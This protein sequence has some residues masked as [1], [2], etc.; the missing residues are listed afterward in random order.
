MS[1]NEEDFVEKIINV[2]THDYILFFTTMGR[3]FRIK[4]YEIPEYGRQSKG[5]PIINLLNLDKDEKITS[6]LKIEKEESN[7]YLIFATKQGL[8]KRTNISEFDSIRN[9]G[10]KAIT[11]KEDDELISVKKT[12]GNREVLMASSEGRMVRFNED[13]IRVMGRSAS[14]VRGINLGSSK[15]INMDVVSDNQ[16][17]LVVTEKGYGKKTPIEEYRITNRGGKGVKTIN[18]TDKNGQLVSFEVI[19]DN[20]KDIMIVTN[21]GI[22]IR[23]DVNQVSTLSRVTQ[24]VRLINLKNEQLVSSVAVIDKVPNE[25]EV[26]ESVSDVTESDVSISE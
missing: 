9:N 8:V 19:N 25:E 5:L 20:E 15:L 26:E 1:T 11:L 23:I 12:D 17:V 18:I 24:G 21:E 4:G 3:V 7:K 10:K 14:G 2:S 13:S 16:S 22:I 6:L